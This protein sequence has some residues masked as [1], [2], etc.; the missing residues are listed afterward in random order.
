MRGCVLGSLSVSVCCEVCG[1]VCA[2]GRRHRWERVMSGPR[3]EA[4]NGVHRG[5]GRSRDTAEEE[6]EGRR[7]KRV[8]LHSL[9]TKM[10]ERQGQIVGDDLTAE[11]CT[12]LIFPDIRGHQRSLPD[13]CLS[14]SEVLK[15]G[16]PTSYT[17]RTLPQDSSWQLFFQVASPSAFSHTL[18][19]PDPSCKTNV[20]MRC[21]ASED[22][23]H[24][25]PFQVGPKHAINVPI[26]Q[27]ADKENGS[28]SNGAKT[29][30]TLLCL[31]KGNEY[32]HK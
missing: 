3:A 7:K 31:T 11:G 30:E 19:F 13:C 17:W 12:C 8:V 4:G 21:H 29:F 15:D 28:T 25:L 9:T 6:R 10:E 20:Y 2:V 27:N 26:T 18:M 5:A 23:N 32:Q 14:Q 22:V 16:E 24:Q 1:D